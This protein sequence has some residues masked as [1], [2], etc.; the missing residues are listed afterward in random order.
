MHTASNEPIWSNQKVT[1]I[2]IASLWALLAS[3]MLVESDIYRYV[4]TLLVLF[5]VARHRCELQEVSRDWL[6]LLCYGWAAYALLRFSFGVVFY[7][8]KG[9][10]EWLYIFPVL[11]PAVGT[12]LYVMRDRLYLACLLLVAAGLIGLVATVDILQI[13]SGERTPPLFH[14]NPIHAGVGSG[15]L[16]I[17]ATYLLIYAIE[18]GRLTNR[19]R[20]PT[21]VVCGA[22]ILLSLMAILGAQSKGVWLALVCTAIPSALL[23][24]LFLPRKWR[25][26]ILSLLVASAVFAAITSSSVVSTVAGSTIAAAEKL[27]TALGTADATAAMEDAIEDPATPGAMRERLMIWYNA[28]ELFQSAP[29]FGRGNLWLQDWRHTTYARVGHTLLHNGFLEIIVRHGLWGLAFLAA[30]M[31]VAIHRLMAARREGLIATSTLSYILTLSFFFLCT[32]TT[33][34]NNRLA[35]GESFFILA[36]GAVF[37]VTLQ[38]KQAL[39]AAGRSSPAQ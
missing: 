15:M 9:A 31:A 34:S 8:E 25:L 38:R 5:V 26:P 6:A 37:A 20:W 36:G 22:T 4:T 18:T 10:S 32:I 19:W 28:S 30:F 11:F 12:A 33:N 21:V 35:I 16:F 27:T 24:L 39:A 7:D 2:F 23:C 1:Q 14:K 29:V 17:S 3:A 13:L